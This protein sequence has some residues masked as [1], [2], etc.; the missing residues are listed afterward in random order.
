MGK[1]LNNKLQCRKNNEDSSKYES[2]FK[3][4]LFQTSSSKGGGP[5]PCSTESRAFTLD[6]YGA[7]QKKSRYSLYNKQKRFHN[8]VLYY[9]FFLG[10]SKINYFINQWISEVNTEITKE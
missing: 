5:S 7:Y 2:C 9:S 6:N 4:K 8:L 10:L 1:S 3:D